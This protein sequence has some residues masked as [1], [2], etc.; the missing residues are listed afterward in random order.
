MS[1]RQRALETYRNAPRTLASL[2]RPLSVHRCAPTMGLAPFVLATSIAVL[3]WL[4][5]Q[6]HPRMLGAAVLMTL[7]SLGAFVLLVLDRLRLF[8]LSGVVVHEEGLAIERAR[9][10]TLLGWDEVSTL[11]RSEGA[12]SEAVVWGWG[13]AVRR[14]G[15]L[16]FETTDSFEQP[17][18]LAVAIIRRDVPRVLSALARGE[19]VRLGSLLLDATGCT[20]EH[21]PPGAEDRTGTVRER[22][23]QRGAEDRTGT[24]RERQ[25]DWVPW[26]R[27]HRT[28]LE[29]S[30]LVV[31]DVEGKV[32][33]RVFCDFRH[34]HQLDFVAGALRGSEGL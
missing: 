11:E 16:L 5:F 32:V 13:S 33:A 12:P 22:P 9:G 27:I 4:G 21:E 23:E 17:R 29:A 18:T 26:A 1:E 28:E 25:S 3:T 6:S 8:H 10:A 14:N 19:R 24:V 34:A 31:F 2:G 15:K 7:V 30:W 20:F